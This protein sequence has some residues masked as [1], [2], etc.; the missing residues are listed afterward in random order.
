MIL[1]KP[2]LFHSA[3]LSNIKHPLVREEIRDY[4]INRQF[5]K[6]LYIK[7]ARKLNPREQVRRILG[8]K[9][10]LLKTGPDTLKCSGYYKSLAL[11]EEWTKQ[12]VDYLATDNRKPKDFTEFLEKHPEISEGVLLVFIKAMVGSETFAPCQPDETVAK[13]KPYCDKLNHFICETSLLEEKIHFL[14]SPLTGCG[15]GVNRIHQMFLHLLRKGFDKKKIPG[16]VQRILSSLGQSLLKDGKLLNEAD[17]VKHLQK[18]FKQFES[19]V[20]P[21][22]KVLGIE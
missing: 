3:F 22:L 14:A 19:E 12:I 1:Q 20:V 2:V 16:E 8:T 15:V 13:A 10:V 4:Y 6:D 11:K 17:G 18:Q 5:R 9:Y 21:L 7:G